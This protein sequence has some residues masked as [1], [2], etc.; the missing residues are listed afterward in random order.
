MTK[1]VEKKNR[2]HCNVIPCV[3]NCLLFMDLGVCI[4]ILS[5]CMR[6]RKRTTPTSGTHVNMMTTANLTHWLLLF[7]SLLVFRFQFPFYD[8]KLDV[9]FINS[10][11]FKDFTWVNQ[12]EKA[13]V[14]IFYNAIIVLSTNIHINI[15]YRSIAKYHWSSFFVSS[16]I[17]GI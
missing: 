4:D 15:S 17:S 3:I 13:K 2:M 6:W 7:L 1:H 10:W 8:L 12:Q 11:K 9:S 16:L 14:C 5:K